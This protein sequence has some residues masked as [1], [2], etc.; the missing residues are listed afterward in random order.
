LPIA[1]WIEIGLF[2]AA[3]PGERLG[4]TLYLEK[5]RVRSGSQT[6]TVTVTEKPARGGID[7]YS[8]LDW[9]EGDN[10]E[11]IDTGN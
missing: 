6:I 10:I 1:E 9:E 5:H 4:R 7:P 8:V 11:G 3:E 2:A